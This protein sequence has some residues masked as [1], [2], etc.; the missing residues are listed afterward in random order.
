MDVAINDAKIMAIAVHRTP[1][2]SPP[3]RAE[4]NRTRVFGM[5]LYRNVNI[6]IVITKGIRRSVRLKTGASA[7]LSWIETTSFSLLNSTSARTASP[8]AIAPTISTVLYSIRRVPKF[9][10]LLTYQT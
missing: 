3:T 5:N 1:P 2:A 7:A 6:A 8:R 4:R 9:L 10:G